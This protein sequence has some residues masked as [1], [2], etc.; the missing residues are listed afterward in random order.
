[1]R[2]GTDAGQEGEGQQNQGDVAVPAKETAHF[3]VVQAEIFGV[4]EMFLDAPAGAKRLDHF[5]QRGAWRA[6]TKE[7]VFWAG[8]LRLRRMSE[9]WCPSSSP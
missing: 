3:V 8:S 5:W 6:K 4:F 2:R 7:K 9:K 1:M